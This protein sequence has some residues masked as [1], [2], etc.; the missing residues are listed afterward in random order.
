MVVATRLIVLQKRVVLE[1]SGL[2]FVVVVVVLRMA[3]SFF[4]LYGYLA[5]LCCWEKNSVA[6]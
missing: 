1:V 6:V 3:L 2:S 4:S 5:W